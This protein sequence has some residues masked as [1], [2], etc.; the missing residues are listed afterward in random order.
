MEEEYDQYL[1]RLSRNYVNHLLYDIEKDPL[2]IF[3]KNKIKEACQERLN[4][5]F[6]GEINGR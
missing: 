6:K 2:G 5:M 4:K 1:E 3:P